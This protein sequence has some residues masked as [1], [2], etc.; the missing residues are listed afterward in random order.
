[1]QAD[2]RVDRGIAI[3]YIISIVE[4]DHV[5]SRLFKKGAATLYRYLNDTGTIGSTIYTTT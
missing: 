2:R 3:S 1:M 5:R 4:C